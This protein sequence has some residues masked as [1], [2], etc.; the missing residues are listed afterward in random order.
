MKKRILFVDDEPL[1]LQ[2]IQRMLH[3][4][5]EHWDMDFAEGGEKAKEHLAQAKYDVVVTDM[6]M[7][8]MN[9]AEVL[10]YVRQHSPGTIRVVL[11][12][13]AEQSVAVKCVGIAHRYYAKPCDGDTLKQMV[14]RLTDTAFTIQNEHLMTLVAQ[15]KHLP[16][17]PAIYSKVVELL[18]DPNSSMDEVGALIGSDMAMTAKILQIVNSSFFGLA[19]HV[20]R[21]SDAAGYLGIDTLKS[22]ILATNVFSQYETKMPNGYSAVKAAEHSQQVGAS[23]RAIAKAEDAPR[24]VV[25]DAFVAGL[26]HDVGELVLASSMP[27]EFERAAAESI[28]SGFPAE[29]EIFGTTHSEVGAYLLGLWGL[30]ARVVE[31][32]SLH[33]LPGIS[34]ALEFSPLT[35]VHVAECLVAERAPAPS[36][37]PVTSPIDMEYLAKIGLTDRLPTWRI[38]VDE[39]LTGPSGQN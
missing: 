1:L 38:A 22:L 34:P 32:I 4:M 27:E 31:A 3:G 35:A 15:L 26:L 6:K 14:T 36:G 13:H 23:A 10:D 30:P 21:P 11:S 29:M 20:A 7:P 19:R 24:S 8:G 16:S 33:H 25:D 39:M 9:G 28:E 2:G 18:H 17:I 12:G 5:R 37:N